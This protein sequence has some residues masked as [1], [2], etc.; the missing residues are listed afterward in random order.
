[1]NNPSSDNLPHRHWCF[2]QHLRDVDSWAEIDDDSLPFFSPP[3]H[4]VLSDYSLVRYAVWQLEYTPTTG[5][6]HLQGYL[7]FRRPF[8]FTGV[9]ALFRTEWE[10][11]ERPELMPPHIEPR[12][13][14]R[15]AARR[16]CMKPETQLA[17]PYEF[18]EWIAGGQGTR[19]D[20]ST[21][22]DSVL[23]GVPLTKID[24]LYPEQAARYQPYLLRLRHQ[25]VEAQQKAPD[26]STYPWQ[27]QLLETL[28]TSP[29][30]RKI[31]WYWSDVGRTGKSTTIRLIE[32]RL[33]FSK[34]QVFLGGKVA[35][36]GFALDP[37]KSVFIFDMCR[38]SF[39]F[40]NYGLLEQIKNA[41]IWCP[42][43]QSCTKLLSNGTPHV[44]VFANQEPDRSKL[45]DDR[46]DVH[47]LHDIMN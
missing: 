47:R 45:S 2:T 24:L 17:E 4:H 20:L 9:R 37:E 43:Y 34:V 1:M 44:L 16:Y 40:L 31:L 27:E 22:R 42:K 7:E 19:V 26:I 14:N 11:E 38:D 10:L 15:D 32:T 5:R 21:V 36:V 30:P 33:G 28:S 12:R 6:R 29:H 25:Y 3:I 41:R 35:D 18:G 8:R 46:W 39:E 13:A 23:S